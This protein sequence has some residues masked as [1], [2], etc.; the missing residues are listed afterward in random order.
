MPSLPSEFFVIIGVPNYNHKK[1]HVIRNSYFIF[2]DHVK[3]LM[4]EI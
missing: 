4:F 1:K 2:R 3:E